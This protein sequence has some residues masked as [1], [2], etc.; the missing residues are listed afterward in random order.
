MREPRYEMALRSG[1]SSDGSWTGKLVKFAG[2]CRIRVASDQI[3]EGW[4]DFDFATM[5]AQINA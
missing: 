3:V 4:N 1:S 5:D 2:N